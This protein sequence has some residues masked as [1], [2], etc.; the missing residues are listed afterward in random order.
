VPACCGLVNLKIEY[1]AT[2]PR[3]KRRQSGA[4]QK[5]QLNQAGGELILRIL[6]R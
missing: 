1:F 4:E 5:D 3:A 6:T 2:P